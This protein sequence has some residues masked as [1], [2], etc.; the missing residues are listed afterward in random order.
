MQNRAL[1]M[2]P[3]VSKRSWKITGRHIFKPIPENC[4]GLTVKYVF[5]KLTKLS[6]F[7]SYE[8]GVCLKKPKH[9][10]KQNQEEM[11]LPIYFI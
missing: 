4:Y 10:K 7:G 8:R 9:T 11:E 1:H 6:S 5:L 2:Q 3:S